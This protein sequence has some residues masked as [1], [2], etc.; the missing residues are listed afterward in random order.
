MG[1][2]D[3]M[4]VNKM[5]S[6]VGR[7]GDL[8]LNVTTVAAAGSGLSDA[9]VIPASATFVNVTGADGTKA[10]ALPALSAVPVGK[11]FFIYVNGGS[12]ELP[13]TLWLFASRLM[14]LS[15]AWLQLPHKQS[16]TQ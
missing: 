1:H 11:V 7:V 9:G 5:E 15:G 13:S 6:A 16:N 12:T 3:E 4:L 14:K 8:G 2:I 10:V